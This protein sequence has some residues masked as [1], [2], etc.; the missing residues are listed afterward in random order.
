MEH[1]EKLA[2]Q[3]EYQRR[4]REKNREKVREQQRRYNQ[5]EKGRAARK[6]ADKRWREN[7]P[8]RA[9]QFSRD[10]HAAN[11][12]TILER[13]K[14]YKIERQFGLTKDGFFEMLAAQGNACAC[15]KTDD[16]NTRGGKG[17]CVDH[18]HST[19]KVRGILCSHCNTALGLANDNVEILES[20]ITY[21]R[22]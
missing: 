11:R 13:N 8:E 16:P 1:E 7:N 19:G 6:A 21:L 3:R 2:K 18:C 20:L 5:S 9:K 22:R 14:W 10:Y 12:K 15:C 4:W 17:W